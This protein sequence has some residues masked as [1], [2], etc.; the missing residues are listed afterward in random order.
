MAT[1]QNPNDSEAEDDE[2]YDPDYDNLVEERAKNYLEHLGEMARAYE[3]ASAI[4]STPDYTRRRCNALEEGEEVVK[5][6]GSRI[7][8]HPMPP[9]GDSTV[10]E[11][12]RDTLL[13][14]VDTYGST[15]QYQQALQIGSINELREFIK[16]N[17][18]IGEGHGLGSNKVLFGPLENEKEE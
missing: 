2:E 8:G 13:H 5:E 1:T 16:K 18:A 3:I 7:I 6:Y 10:L 4:G 15:G 17:I 11:G 9:N 14:I 12:S